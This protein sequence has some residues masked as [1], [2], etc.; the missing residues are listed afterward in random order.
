M[1]LAL[2]ST[3]SQR[4][5]TY[6]QHQIFSNATDQ[7]RLAEQLGFGTAWFPEH[8]FTNYSICPNATML[9]GYVAGRTSKIKVGPAVVVVPL[10]HP[11]RVLE[12]LALVDQLSDGRLAIGLG[13]GY[14]EFEFFKFGRDMSKNRVYFSE[15]LDIFD[16]YM[17]TGGIELDG[18]LAQIPKTL[19]TLK[20]KQ[21][22]PA[23]YV[24]SGTGEEIVQKRMIAGNYAAIVSMVGNTTAI[25]AERHRQ[26]ELA[27]RKAGGA[28]AVMPF[29]LNQYLYVTRDPAEARRAAESVIYVMRV[30]SAMKGKNVQLDG[31]LMKDVP[32]EGEPTV[33]EI[34]SR[35]SIGDPEVVAERLNQQINLMSPKQMSF[36]MGLPG[37]SSKDIL[38]SMESFGNY[39]I[40]KL[41]GLKI[42]EPRFAQAGE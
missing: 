7:V 33:D 19:F 4:D 25:M 41:K 28:E 36:I 32:F 40:P 16:Q 42:E 8:H 18:E 2:F 5:S 1:E 17:R 24:A 35:L 39:V 20:L 26:I 6:N 11:I 13:G 9:A 10:H 29:A 31:S 12:E 21:K 14:Q 30:H 38:R 22:A 27:Y 23:V 15:F 3:V 34:L 37:L